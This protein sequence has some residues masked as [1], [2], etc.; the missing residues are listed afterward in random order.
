MN[1][2]K[3]KEEIMCRGM[4]RKSNI[5]RDWVDLFLQTEKIKSWSLTS[6]RRRIS[7]WISLIASLRQCLGL[8]HMAWSQKS[9]LND[10]ELHSIF[11]FGYFK[12]FLCGW[13]DFSSWKIVTSTY[14][15]RAY[16]ALLHIS[17]MISP[18]QSRAAGKRLRR[19]RRRD[20]T[21]LTQAVPSFESSWC[22]VL[23]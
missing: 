6:D 19:R 17:H 14:R 11:S 16:S 23:T 7:L 21:A 22:R 15:I 13:T 10:G 9:V 20:H 1:I 8:A 18:P 4:L 5:P 12:I 2:F 3:C